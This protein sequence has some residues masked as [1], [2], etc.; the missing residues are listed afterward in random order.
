MQSRNPSPDQQKV[1]CLEYHYLYNQLAIT[2][3]RAILLIGREIS[4]GNDLNGNF[5]CLSGGLTKPVNDI[6]TFSCHVVTKYSVYRVRRLYYIYYV[7]YN[8][9]AA[10]CMTAHLSCLQEHPAKIILSEIE[11]L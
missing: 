8:R 6:V 10:S 11:E 3:N 4:P 1:H 2:R 5:E 7:L 9:L